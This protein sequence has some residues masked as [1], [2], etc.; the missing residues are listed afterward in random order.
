MNQFFTPSFE[1]EVKTIHPGIN[2]V[3][4][5]VAMLPFFYFPFFWKQ[6]RALKYDSYEKLNQDLEP[7]RG[8]SFQAISSANHFWV[9]PIVGTFQKRP[10]WHKSLC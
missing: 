6:M 1:T 8:D 9:R 4:V 10:W 7:T 2:P 5:I 3:V